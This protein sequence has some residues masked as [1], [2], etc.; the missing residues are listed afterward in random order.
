MFALVSAGGPSCD[1]INLA[2]A[3]QRI[4]AAFDRRGLRHNLNNVGSLSFVIVKGT[5]DAELTYHD[6]SY[7]EQRT[8]LLI[9]R[10]QAELTEMVKALGGLFDIR[11]Q[12]RKASCQQ[13]I[14]PLQRLEDKYHAS[15]IR[16][17]RPCAG[18]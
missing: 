8:I 12:V 17:S 4:G 11:P 6:K 13:L 1:H 5:K 2:T 18:T 15:I 7:A 3:I 10:D 14:A 9:V 16:N